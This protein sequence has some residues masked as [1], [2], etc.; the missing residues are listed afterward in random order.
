MRRVPVILLAVLTSCTANA[1]A[2]QSGDGASS[3]SD[4]LTGQPLH[5]APD[6]HQWTITYSYPEDQK[7][8]GQGAA[9]GAANPFPAS[10]GDPPR[11]ILTTKTGTIIHEETTSVSGK[12]TDA[13]QVDGS[14]YIKYP[15]Q[16][17]WMACEKANPS[18]SATRLRVA[19]LLP[20]SGFRGL[21]WIKRQAY[22][23]RTKTDYG[24][25]LIFVPG[26]LS[27]VG[28]D[29]SS[30]KLDSFPILAYVD[31]ATRLP[32]R[33]RGQDGTRMFTFNQ[34]AS[35]SPQTLPDALTAEIKADNAIQ[36]QRDAAPRREY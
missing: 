32:V 12:L 28:G 3:T 8:N 11:T 36:A 33:I 23:G 24:D 5:A 17:L 2:Q 27:A 30:Q 29:L 35:N 16:S 34:L 19:L 18:E 21:D 9:T 4:V 31:A 25:C 26:G 13:W 14:F 20:P 22:A 1:S 7:T 10:M 15:G 6:F